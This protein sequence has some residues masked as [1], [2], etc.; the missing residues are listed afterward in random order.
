MFFFLSSLLVFY[1]MV[2]SGYAIEAEF[3]LLLR[4][5]GNCGLGLFDMLVT[6]EVLIGLVYIA[7]HR[8]LELWVLDL[9]G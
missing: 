2:R 4:I 1:N 9:K 3:P 6:R 8:I 5:S 7:R